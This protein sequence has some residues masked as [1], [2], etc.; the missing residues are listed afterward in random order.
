M[1]EGT[2]DVDRLADWMDGMGLGSGPITDIEP[3]SG[4]TQNII[5]RFRRGADRFVLRR[6]AHH[7]RANSN[8][9]MLREARVLKALAGSDVPHPALVASCADTGI[10]G[11]AFYLMEPVDGFFAPGGLPPLHAGDASIRHAMGLHMAQAAAQLG[12]VDHVA[13]GLTDFGKPA[14]FRERQATRWRAQLDSYAE[15]AG[16]PGPSALPQ[17]DRIGAW[18]EDH[19]P[20]TPFHPGILHGD[21]HIAN[22]LFR[23]DGPQVAAIIDWELATV[24]DPLLDLGWQLATWPDPDGHIPDPGIS[25]AGQRDFPTAGEIIAHYG[26]HSGRD[27]SAMPWYVVLA[28]YKLGIILEGSHARA[29]AGKA[30]RDIGDRL[31][32]VC[33][34]L[35]DRALR[36][37][38]Q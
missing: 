22:L 29:C 20:R 10:L 12:S 24:G 19:L 27:L 3:L 17:I 13:A 34:R 25:V 37:M 36:W 4:G 21:F 31:H 38:A 6:P 23:T 2:V 7:L 18:L 14:G 32:Q 16:W 15:H 28:C 9:T 35:L 1:A 8:E 11:A 33:L 26:Q 30:P 5:L